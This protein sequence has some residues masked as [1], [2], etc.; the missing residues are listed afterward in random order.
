MSA[1]E[2]AV[3]ISASDEATPKLRQVKASVDSLEASTRRAEAS[4]RN[5][6]GA[7]A[8]LQSSTRGF[9]TSLNQTVDGG[10]VGLGALTVAGIG[11]G[12]KT[13]SSFEQSNIALGT[14]LGSQERGTA[15]FGQLQTFAAKTPFQLQ[16]VTQAT[17]RLLAYGFAAKD[18]LPTL[19]AIGD[20]S[21]GLGAGQQGVDS[22]TRAIGQ[23]KAKGR[24]QGDELLQLQEAGVPAL[25][26]LA[27]GLG[28]S[29]VDLQKSITAGL[30]SADQAIPILLK[31]LES[32]F[33]GLM[34]RQNKTLGGQVSNFKDTLSIELAKAVQPSIPKLTAELPGLAAS[35]G[36]A[37]EEIAPQIPP[38]VDSLVT[39]AP[40]AVDVA[41]GFA[42]LATA[43]APLVTTVSRL[44]DGKVLEVVVGGLVGLRALSFAGGAVSAVKG[45]A[46]AFGLLKLNS[47][48]ISTTVPGLPGSGVPPIT[49]SRGRPKSRRPGNGGARSA[50]LLASLPLIGDALLS[51]PDDFRRGSKDDL[52]SNPFNSGAYIAGNLQANIRRDV[53]RAFRGS[54]EVAPVVTTGERLA[55]GGGPVFN[56]KVDVHN[57]TSNVDV[58]RAVL[59]AHDQALKSYVQQRR[60]RG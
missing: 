56:T 28:K 48:G 3:R 47:A 7:Y 41:G 52:S 12:L 45:L 21:A 5:W 9:Q 40:V 19:T 35:V 57:P 17:Q 51:A 4:T 31:G 54:S 43:A 60:E 20:A 25:D 22:I 26:I 16:G 29:G 15:L 13:A 24:V 42:K 36:K 50:G 53:G 8:K 23:I 49:D 32:R 10:I 39:L 33:G 46:E 1:E 11:Y 59:D 6:G 44:A 18:V 37:I 58:T 2:V 38:L 55:N 27:K 30:V 14:L 34:E